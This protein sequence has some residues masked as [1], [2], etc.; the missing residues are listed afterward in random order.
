MGTVKTEEFGQFFLISLSQCPKL[1]P[2]FSWPTYLILSECRYLLQNGYVDIITSEDGGVSGWGF[3]VVI[4]SI[5]VEASRME[6]VYLWEIPLS[7]LAP[8]TTWGYSMEE[9]LH[10]LRCCPPVLRLRASRTVRSKFL[11]LI[12]CPVCD[13]LL[14]QPKGTKAPCK[15][16]PL[17]LFPR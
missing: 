6:S 2:W 13:T 16:T 14:L 1:N 4:R 3:E 10:Q 12:S 15:Y 17:Q 9:S 7:S 5:W 11:L 8:P